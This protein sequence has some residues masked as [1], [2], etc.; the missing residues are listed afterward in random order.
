[1]S[2]YSTTFMNYTCNT[3]YYVHFC[4]EVGSV[5]IICDIIKVNTTDTKTFCNLKDDLKSTPTDKYSDSTH[6]HVQYV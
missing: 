4:L 3:T 5:E 6:T 1:M 2:M